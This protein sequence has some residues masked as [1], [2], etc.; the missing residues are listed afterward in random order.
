[1]KFYNISKKK[2]FRHLIAVVII[3]T[4]VI[5]SS[6]FLSNFS[7]A[8]EPSESIWH[9]DFEITCDNVLDVFVEYNNTISLMGQAFMDSLGDM[10]D[11]L[12][13]SSEEIESLR[14]EAA[15][16]VSGALIR[17]GVQNTTVQDMGY[18]LH[19]TLEECL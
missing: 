18:A 4:A 17:A 5:C 1:M 13:N 19:D 2:G 16:E 11:F 10:N 7:M 3:K 15:E 8:A 12:N 9:E 14:R 6:L